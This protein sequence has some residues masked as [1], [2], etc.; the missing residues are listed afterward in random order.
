MTAS[1]FQRLSFLA[2]LA[3]ALPMPPARAAT[4]ESNFADIPPKMQQFVNQGVVC[5][6]VTLVATRDK[7]LH[8]AAVGTTD[9]TRKMQTDDLFWIASMSKP[10][11]A[12]AAALLVDDGKLAFDDPVEKYIPEFKNIRYGGLVPVP[13]PGARGAGSGTGS[14]LMLMDLTRPITLRDLLT[15]TSG[16]SDAY[17]QTQPHWTLQQF[18]QQIAS[19]PLHFQPGTKWQYSTAGIDAVGRVVEVASGMPFDQFL[20]KRLFDPLH[21]TNTSF[22]IAPDNAARYAHTYI[23]NA[24]TNKL[25]D[26]PITYLY[27]TEVT[28]K[29]RPPLGGAGLFSTAEDVAK[30]YQMTLNG[31]RAPDSP[32]RPGIPIL[33]P[34][35]LAAMTQNQIGTLT[36]RPG[37]PWGYG[38]CVV[39]DPTAME[40]NNMLTPNSYGHGGAF[41]TNSWV[42]PKRGVVYVLMLERDKMGNPDNSPMHIAFQDMAAKDLDKK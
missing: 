1:F 11:T 16:L 10:I 22:W 18:A 4:P 32:N 6:I 38:F 39:A 19:Q 35:T 31:G 26:T 5:G 14:A 8:L 15:H 25:V 42:D 40:A 20:Q 9:G 21:M 23:L 2:L 41:G 34:E 36:A 3:A 37:M 12:V 17:T 24:Q 30:F 28:D 27:G 29:Q 33:K 13:S 7:V